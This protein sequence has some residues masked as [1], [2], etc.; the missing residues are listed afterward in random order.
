MA[1]CRSGNDSLTAV[2]AVRTTSV[3]NTAPNSDPRPPTATQI[4][5]WMPSKMP[6]ESRIDDAD[7]RHEQGAAQSSHATRRGQIPQY[8]ATWDRSPRN[9]RVFRRRAAQ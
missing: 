7:L 4:T 1:Y 9:E 6:S 3:P 5:I 8:A 2:W